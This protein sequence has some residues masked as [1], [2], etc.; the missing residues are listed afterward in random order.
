MTTHPGEFAEAA[1]SCPFAF[2]AA[3]KKVAN[4][5]ESATI[6]AS[7]SEEKM[8]DPGVPCDVLMETAFHF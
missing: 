2:T 7:R 4:A 1:G 8:E 6:S 5:N 3:S